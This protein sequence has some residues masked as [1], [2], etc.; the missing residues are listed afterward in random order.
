MKSSLQKYRRLGVEGYARWLC[1]ANG[2][3]Y[4][5][6]MASMTDNHA[7]HFHIEAL[8]KPKEEPNPLVQEEEVNPFPVEIQQYDSLTV[9]ELREL[10]KERELPVYGTKAEIVF[11]LK[12]HDDGIIPEETPESPA[13]EVALE[14]DSEAPAEEVA[15]SI[16]EENN[17]EQESSNEQEPVIENE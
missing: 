16:G 1:D 7:L 8:L 5:E 3:E 17:D 6:D 9:A 10:C 12:Q 14:G 11:R 13:E 2:V 15:A 4:T